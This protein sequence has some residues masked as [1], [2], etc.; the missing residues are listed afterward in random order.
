M[1]F[2]FF[3]ICR[4]QLPQRPMEKMKRFKRRLSLTL[5]GSQTIDE[6]LS[7][8]AEQMTVEENSSKD[9]GECV[10]V[11]VLLTEVCW[12]MQFFYVL[13]VHSYRCRLFWN[14]RLPQYFDSF[15][16]SSAAVKKFLF[17]FTWH[18][19]CLYPDFIICRVWPTW[20]TLPRYIYTL[21]NKN[22]NVIVSISQYIRVISRAEEIV[23]A[24]KK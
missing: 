2:F 8:L 7:E 6:S 1:F 16:S 14:F 15:L 5:R 24:G 21:F 19:M 17:F 4:P 20:L 11:F 22:C 10:C 12:S 9:S 23:F 3:F 13:F 18:N